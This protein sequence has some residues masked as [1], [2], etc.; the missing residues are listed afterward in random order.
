MHRWTPKEECKIWLYSVY[1]STFFEFSA[2]N[3]QFL[4]NFFEFCVLAPKSILKFDFFYFANNSLNNGRWVVLTPFLDFQYFWTF[5]VFLLLKSLFFNTIFWK[6]HQ[7]FEGQRR[8]FHQEIFELFPRG[9][10]LLVV[11][12]RFFLICS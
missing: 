9:K 2:A 3:I 7:V 10:W 12:I 6:N 11:K 5:W 1:S 8:L 4:I